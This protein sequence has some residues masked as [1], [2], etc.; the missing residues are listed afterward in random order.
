[1]P[2]PL[3]MFLPVEGAQTL[4]R[5]SFSREFPCSHDRQLIF[6]PLYY[7]SNDG[8]LGFAGIQRGLG[9]GFPKKLCNSHCS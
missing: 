4:P 1:M 9:G 7:L 3:V 8:R 5:R 2:V 6:V